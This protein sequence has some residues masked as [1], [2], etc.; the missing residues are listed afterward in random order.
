MLLQEAPVTD[1]VF[2][3]IL[4][5]EKYSADAFSL[6]EEIAPVYREKYHRTREPEA[7]KQELGAGL[8]LSRVLG[9]NRDDLLV[10]NEYGKPMLANEWCCFSLSHSGPY[11][12]LAVSQTPIGVDIENGYAVPYK[13]L[14]RV[15]GTEA[16]E[17]LL[18][19]NEG[20]EEYALLS[21]KLWTEA[22][23]AL[24]AEGTGFFTD[25]ACNPGWKKDRN[26]IGVPLENGY[27][28]SCARKA[29]IDNLSIFDE[30]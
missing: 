30:L 19:M 29:P 3:Y 13:A 14:K 24:K 8:L 28:V 5:T 11:T 26:F 22:E 2:L 1:T 10:W 18:F 15:V 4:H 27:Y 23:A 9:V 20:T 25:P 6:L 12:V 7:K 21:G 17:P 16:C